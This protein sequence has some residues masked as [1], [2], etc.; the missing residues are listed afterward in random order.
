[1]LSLTSTAFREGEAIPLAHARDGADCS[2]PLAWSGAP[3]G[4]VSFALVCDDPDAPRGR[5]VHW[6]LYDVPAEAK[7]LAAGVG[8]SQRP[9]AGGVV[10]TNDFGESGWG[11]P[12]PPRGHGIH[13]YEFRLYALD[14]KLGLPPGA[15]KDELISAMK[16]RILA[17]VRLTGTYR[18]D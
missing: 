18:R 13:H 15:S 4:T 5:W 11:G 9:T 3:E 1:V 17:E 14:R 12:A 7:G 16:G 8:K 10:G 2:P 6:V